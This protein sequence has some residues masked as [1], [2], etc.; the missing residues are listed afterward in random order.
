MFL[1]ESSLEPLSPHVRRDDPMP[2]EIRDRCAEIQATW[3]PLEREAWLVAR[4]TGWVVT[5]EGGVEPRSSSTAPDG[6]AH[7]SATGGHKRFI[8]PV[9]CHHA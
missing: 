2:D 8:N 9:R 4:P 5:V 1:F 6:T 7:A 3:G